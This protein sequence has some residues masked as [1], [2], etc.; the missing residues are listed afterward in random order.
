MSG[1][2][3][4]S[5]QDVLFAPLAGH[6]QANYYKRSQSRRLSAISMLALAGTKPL[7]I[8]FSRCCM[9]AVGA[10]Q[11]PPLSNPNWRKRLAFSWFCFPASASNRMNERLFRIAAASCRLVVV[12]SAKTS[13]CARLR[14]ST[15]SAPGH[16]HH[17]LFISLAVHYI[18]VDRCDAS[19]P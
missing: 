5:T 13:N 14:R 17:H 9:L 10:R 18:F 6:A 16:P 2:P 19:P 11:K 1:E 12:F 7:S 15:V 8:S 3:G 4:L